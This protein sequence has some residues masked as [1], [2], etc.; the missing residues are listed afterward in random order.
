MARPRP[1]RKTRREESQLLCQ[2]KRVGVLPVRRATCSASADLAIIPPVVIPRLTACR[3]LSLARGEVFS[4]QTPPLP[5]APRGDG[6]YSETIQALS[7]QALLKLTEQKRSLVGHLVRSMAAGMYVGA[8]IVLIFTVGGLLSAASPAVVRIL[9]GV[10]FGGALTI[11]I[12]AGS[13]LFTGSNL[14]A[15]ARRPERKATAAD[16]ASQLGV[17]VGR[18]PGRQRPG[19]RGWSWPPAC[20]TQRRPSSR[21][22][23]G[24]STTKMNIAPDQLFL[25]A[26]WPTGSSAWACGWRP[27]SRARRPG[28]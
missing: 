17:D 3:Q 24:S 1:V 7:D 6:M 11:V 28:Y 9:M 15:D 8:A 18:Q 16:L 14:V 2:A 27:A 26:S 22:S 13:E 20:W 19:R 21:S 10:C 25:R 12:F 5:L 4:D 23:S